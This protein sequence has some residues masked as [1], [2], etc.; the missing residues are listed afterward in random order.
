[1]RTFFTF[2]LVITGLY[3][4]SQVVVSTLPMERNVVLEEYTGITCQYC[5]DGHYLANL[6]ASDNPGRVV[7]VNIHQGSFAIPS[8]TR[9]DFRTQWGDALATNAAIGGYPAGTINRQVFPELNNT[10]ELARNQWTY[11]ATKV[12]PEQSPVNI[13]FWS[14]I[15]TITRELTVTVELYYTKSS[16]QST[17]YINVALLQ[18]SVLGWQT[19]AAGMTYPNI[20]TNNYVHNHIL[21][22]FLTGQWGD[23]VTNT[24]QG[25]TLTRTYTYTIPDTMPASLN[26]HTHLILANCQVAVYVAESHNMIYT[27]F[28]AALG[29]TVNG[30]TTVYTGTLTGTSPQAQQGVEGVEGTDHVYQA[31]SSLGATEDFQFVLTSNAPGDWTYKYSYNSVDYTDT[32]LITINSGDTVDIDLSVTPGATAKFAKFTLTMTSTTY[33]GSTPKSYDYYVMSGIT[34]LIVNGSGAFGDGNSYDFTQKYIDGLNFAFNTHFDAVPASIM[35]KASDEGIL[36]VVNN[37]YLNI[38]WTFPSF[39]DDEATALMGFMDNGGNVFVAGQDIGWDIQSGSGYGTVT[40]KNLFTNY[41]HAVYSTDGTGTNTPLI[42]TTDPIFMNVGTSAVVDVYAGNLYPDQINP[43]AGAIIIFKYTSAT[44]TKNAG[45]RFE[46]STYKVVYL[47]I[48]L[49]NISTATVANNIIKRAHDWFYGYG[50]SSIVNSDCANSCNGSIT[51][52]QVGGV[53]TP[54]YLWS[55][56]ATDSV[57]TGLCAGTYTV[58]I[59]DISGTLVLSGTITAPAALALTSDH[60]NATCPTCADGSAWVS[61]IGESGNYIFLWDDP[62]SST[63]DTLGNVLPGTYNVTVTDTICGSTVT[64]SV[65]VNDMI[66]VENAEFGNVSIYPNPANSLLFIDFGNNPAESVEITDI[67]GRTISSCNVSANIVSIDISSLDSGMYLLKMQKDQTQK[68][69]RIQVIH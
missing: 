61:V 66:N 46:N 68:I 20:N 50:I 28:D 27:G 23:T 13:A 41:F 16:P 47:G 15:D 7:L 37:L 42:P 67:S 36:D 51:I 6:L 26:N 65:T 3:V 43:G 55:N 8:G 2:C 5:P 54:S 31:V 24:T 48:G 49:E 60:L 45:L 59:S 52:T 62:G 64:G 9:P 18:D 22:N 19:G 4:N 1:M 35:Q 38:G 58:T 32:A 12:F 40:T 11:A 25:S 53:S 69:I 56:S 10:I 44:G 34:D 39:T 33:P 17:N 14:E 29:D 21:R 30:I 57:A 63:N